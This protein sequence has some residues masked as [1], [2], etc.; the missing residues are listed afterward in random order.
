MENI[1]KQKKEGSMT[2]EELVAALATMDENTTKAYLNHEIST[3]K[4]KSYITRMHQR[5]CKVRDERERV[6]VLGG[7]LL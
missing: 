2:W 6:A 4:R 7:Q 3:H 5:Y 1:M